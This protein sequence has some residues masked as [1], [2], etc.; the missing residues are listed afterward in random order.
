MIVD[1]ADD[2]GLFLYNMVI[3]ETSGSG[4]AIVDYLPRQLDSKRCMIVTTRGRD[5]GEISGIDRR[6]PR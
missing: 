1:N 4:R 6:R 3:E 2:A 5:I